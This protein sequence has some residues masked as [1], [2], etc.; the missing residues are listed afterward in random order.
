MPL[1]RGREGFAMVELRTRGELAVLVLVL[2]E[3]LILEWEGSPAA[4][5][6]QLP[7]PG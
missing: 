4:W 6:P 2:Q 7:S 5:S 3:N 1:L